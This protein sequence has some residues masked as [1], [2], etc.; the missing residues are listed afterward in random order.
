M[1]NGGGSWNNNWSGHGGN[2][3]YNNGGW[4]NQS[5]WENGDGY[6]R[7]NQNWANDSFGSGYQQQ[8]Y[9]GG[10]VRNNYNQRV[11]PYGNSKLN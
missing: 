9:G 8:G 4:Y 2:G 1:N 3:G 11:Q 5:P 10:P 6:E 7:N